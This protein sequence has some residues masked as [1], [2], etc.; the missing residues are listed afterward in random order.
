MKLAKC[1]ECRARIEG[2]TSRKMRIGLYDHAAATGHYRFFGIRGFGDVTLKRE[3]VEEWVA[4]RQSK[5]END[6]EDE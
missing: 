5:A 1:A 4:K 3:W 6:K 2:S